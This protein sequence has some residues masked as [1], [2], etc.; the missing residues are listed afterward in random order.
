MS[1]EW[2]NGFGAFS[3]GGFIQEV[4]TARY[5]NESGTTESSKQDQD[6]ERSGSCA[7]LFKQISSIEN[8]YYNH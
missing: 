1:V 4:P 7:T 3:G 5:D 2:P 6:E 8:K